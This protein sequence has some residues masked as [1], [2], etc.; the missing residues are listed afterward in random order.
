MPQK[1]KDK[2]HN[3]SVR[4]EDHLGLVR[5]VVYKYCR[6]GRLEDSELYSVGCLALVEAANTFDS[7]KSKFCTWAT[8]LIRQ[9]V[10]DEIRKSARSREKTDDSAPEP[11]AGSSDDLHLEL[12][13]DMVAGKESDSDQ[14]RDGKEVLRG[15]FLEQKSLSELG[16][17]LNLSKEGVRKRMNSALSMVR[18]KNHS[19]LENVP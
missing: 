16:R 7:T 8:R 18:R 6:S 4:V 19:V 14:E 3:E 13:M 5:S 15:Y 11:A 12:V 10:V 2:T 17:E 1:S 9:S